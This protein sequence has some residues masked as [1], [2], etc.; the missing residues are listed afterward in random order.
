MHLG[1]PFGV[2]FAFCPFIKEKKSEPKINKRTII[3]C[4]WDREVVD[5]WGAAFDSWKTK[6]EKCD[7]KEITVSHSVIT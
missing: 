5:L 1:L 2:C 3:A 7:E 6:G 4:P